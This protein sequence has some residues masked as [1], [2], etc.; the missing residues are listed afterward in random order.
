MK[1]A[2]FSATATLAMLFT[3]GA[4]QADPAKPETREKTIIKI[5]KSGDGTR[6]I[7]DADVSSAMEKCK[8]SA[9]KVDTSTETKGKDGKSEKTRIIICSDGEKDQAQMR[10]ALEKARERLANVEALSAETKARAL[11]RI[12]EQLN[13]L[14]SQAPDGK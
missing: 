4:A 2:P 9:S 7:S 13:R 6:S 5:I 11:A 12:D 14:K 8:A 1:I 3:I 10:S